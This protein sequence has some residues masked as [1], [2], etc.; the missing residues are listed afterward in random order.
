MRF[1]LLYLM[2][3][4]MIGAQATLRTDPSIIGIIIEIQSTGYLF[5]Y[6]D[7]DGEIHREFF[8]EKDLRPYNEGI[9][10]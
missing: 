10:R 8:L 6:T 1:Y 3:K 2:P 9:G 7:K 5:E 4:Y